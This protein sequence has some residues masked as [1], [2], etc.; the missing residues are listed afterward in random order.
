M[1]RKREVQSRVLSIG[2]E[3]VN[4][5]ARCRAQDA[6]EVTAREAKRFVPA[7]ITAASGRKSA[8]RETTRNMFWSRRR[9]IIAPATNPQKKPRTKY[10]RARRLFLRAAADAT[11]PLVAAATVTTTNRR[12]KS[13][14]PSEPI[15]RDLR[16]VVC[17][18]RLADPITALPQLHCWP[19][20]VTKASMKR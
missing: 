4:K 8:H 12:I 5:R 10:P 7:V 3:P 14:G 16:A 15:C 9:R 6:A 13:I 1:H 17:V 11:N 19:M 20:F 18:D 2:I